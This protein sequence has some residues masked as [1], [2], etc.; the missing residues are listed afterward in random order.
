MLQ[1]IISQPSTPDVR[2]HNLMVHSIR[3]SIPIGR[4]A[5]IDAKLRFNGLDAD[6]TQLDEL[7]DGFPQPSPTAQSWIIETLTA[8]TNPILRLPPMTVSEAHQFFNVANYLGITDTST[9]LIRYLEQPWIE[10]PNK[11]SWLTNDQRAYTAI[12]QLNE[13]DES[14]STHYEVQSRELSDPQLRFRFLIQRLAA[15]QEAPH[16]P[17]E[18]LW[19]FISF[20]DVVETHFHDLRQRLIT[21]SFRLE[22]NLAALYTSVRYLFTPETMSDHQNAILSSLSYPKT[23]KIAHINALYRATS[24]HMTNDQIA[25]ERN[26]LLTST[27][28]QKKSPILTAFYASFDP[29][30][31]REQ[32]IVERDM[33]I[34]SSI[35]INEKEEILTQ[36]HVT[37][38]PC[39]SPN[40]L[41]TIRHEVLHLPIAH[42]GKARIIQSMY[43]RWANSLTSEQIAAERSA[44]LMSAWPSEL[45]FSSLTRLYQASGHNL[46]TEAMAVEHGQLLLGPIEPENAHRLINI[47]FTATRAPISTELIRSERTAILELNI[48]NTTKT[49]LLHSLYIAVRGHIPGH[50]IG[51]EREAI[52]DSNI[53]AGIGNVLLVLYKSVHHPL[54]TAELAME[55][56]AI[57]DSG[58]AETS[59]QMVLMALY[60]DAIPRMP[61]TTIVSEQRAIL[62]CNLPRHLKGDLIAQL[63]TNRPVDIPDHRTDEPACCIVS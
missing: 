11:S 32:F 49:D 42:E 56:E 63:T 4:S 54:S 29:P 52:L 24:H 14:M 48:V 23:T 45:K 43:D 47:I 15:V 41:S 60:Q 16:T 18:L 7:F 33:I 5:F 51:A 17:F 61:H 58:L 36:L 55:R 38:C 35:D 20:R 2:V 3:Y 27:H 31:S 53:R 30:L 62:R 12:H 6:S 1:R 22:A 21:P 39:H 13:V 25:H 37:N 10:F 8:P 44:I 59:K 28:W 40:D 57:L 46:S 26:R 9:A 19:L 50:H 34:R